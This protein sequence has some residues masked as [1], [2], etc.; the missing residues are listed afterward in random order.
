MCALS[1]IDNR[2]FACIVNRIYPPELQFN[3]ANASDPKPHF[4]DLR[5]SIRNRFVS[6]KI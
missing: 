3:K 5:L 6:A 4:S 1:N 2:N